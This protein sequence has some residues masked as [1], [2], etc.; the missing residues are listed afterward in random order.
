[1]GVVSLTKI[2][3]EKLIQKLLEHGKITELATESEINQEDYQ[4]ATYFN[5]KHGG[6]LTAIALVLQM[7]NKEDKKQS[8]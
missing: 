3:A 1:M 4:T 7:K 6:L 2:D 8:T 5:G